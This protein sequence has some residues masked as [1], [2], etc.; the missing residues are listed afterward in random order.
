MANT[1]LLHV[2]ATAKDT[3]DHLEM[4]SF[5]NDSNNIKGFCQIIDFFCKTL[6]NKGDNVLWAGYC[7][8]KTPRGDSKLHPA[9]CLGLFCNK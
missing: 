2:L 7:K 8:I 1:I 6:S 9:P 3:T 5:L 4:Q